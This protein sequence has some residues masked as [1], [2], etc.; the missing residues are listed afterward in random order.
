MKRSCRKCKNGRATHPA[1]PKLYVPWYCS[2]WA[3]RKIHKDWGKFRMDR[4]WEDPFEQFVENLLKAHPEG[5]LTRMYRL[6]VDD[7][8]FVGRQENLEH[9]TLKALRMAG[10][11]VDE[12]AVKAT[13]PKNVSGGVEC[14]PDLA[15]RIDKAESWILETFYA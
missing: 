6:Y 1:S 2:Y 15:A 3:Y 5:L 8:H 9:D 12:A 4:Y 11:Q 14:P 10:E 7:V 13:P